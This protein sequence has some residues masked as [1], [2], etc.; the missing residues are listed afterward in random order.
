MKLELSRT[1]KILLAWSVIFLI[2]AEVVKLLHI[3]GKAATRI[4]LVEV[5][6]AMLTGIAF[7]ITASAKN[8]STASGSER[9]GSSD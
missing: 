5:V 8:N 1:Q 6:V 3:E 2:L 7:G 9:V 4:G